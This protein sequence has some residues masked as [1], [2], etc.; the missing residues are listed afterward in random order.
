MNFPTC[1]LWPRLRGGGAAG[2]FAARMP[3]RKKTCELTR[4]QLAIL[5]YSDGMIL[6]LQF[7]TDAISA[8]IFLRYSQGIW[9]YDVLQWTARRGGNYQP[10]RHA[11]DAQGP[12]FP[13][14][15][16]APM[17]S[18]VRIRPAWQK[19]PEPV[20]SSRYHI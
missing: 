7:R 8:A 16:L 11:G 10:C 15:P 3:K 6:S 4:S 5:H 18:A 1:S 20:A 12:L 14:T 9:W 19:P 17:R 13:V 2:D